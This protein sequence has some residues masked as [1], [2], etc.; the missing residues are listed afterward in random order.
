M[1]GWLISKGDGKEGHGL[2]L[3]LSTLLSGGILLSLCYL[4]RL[5]QTSSCCFQPIPLVVTPVLSHV[6]SNGCKVL[7]NEKDHPTRPL[8]CSRWLF[9]CLPRTSLARLVVGVISYSQYLC[10][11]EECAACYSF[12]IDK[13][14]I[15]S[16][17]TTSSASLAVPNPNPK[18]SSI[19]VPLLYFRR[20]LKPSFWN[21][22]V[23]R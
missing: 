9:C 18:S 16:S 8:A 14:L 15:T 12:N 1:G 6:C 7:Q 17:S 10:L 13:S 20:S 22:P 23:V 21:D 11:I 3:T 4:F 19:V 2:S 5:L